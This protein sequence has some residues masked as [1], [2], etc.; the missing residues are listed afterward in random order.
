VIRKLGEGLE[1][2]RTFVADEL[3]SAEPTRLSELSLVRGLQFSIMVG[4]G[5]VRDHLLLRASALTYFTVLAVVPMLAIVSSIATAVGVTENVLDPVFEEIAAISPQVAEQLRTFVQDANIAGLGTLGAITLFL[6]TLLGISNV[7]RSLNHIWGIRQ[8]RAWGRRIPDYLAVLI[9]A[10]LLMGAGL[11]I[12]LTVNSQWIVQKLLEFPVFAVA[13]DTGLQQLPTILLGL[14]FAFLF[15][16]LPN[17]SVRPFAAL[18]G[19]FVAAIGVDIAR[20]IYVGA[21]LGAARADALYGSFAQLPLFFIWTYFFWAIVLFGAEIAFAYQNLPTYRREVRGHQTSQAS[22]EAVA[23]R[24]TL[25]VAKR[26]RAG[27]EPVDAAFLSDRFDTPVRVV[28]DVAERL[29]ARGI[30]SLR[31]RDGEDPA[32]QLARPAEH[33]QVADVI[34][35]LRGARE[36]SRGESDGSRLVDALLSE[37]DESTIKGAAGQS[38]R[39]LLASLPESGDVDP[40]NA[41]G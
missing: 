16:F 12:A 40:L 23:L 35:A 4:E 10:P 21:A 15:W 18:L 20:E 28:R 14:A 25:E 7:E 13:Y 29:V 11:S 32:L 9:V 19:G 3:W 6:T 37:I 38:V 27:A 34:G 36:P 39:D 5:F 22:R 24:T 8:H 2:A 26:F 41:R 1:R 30:L 31:S 17:T 33:I